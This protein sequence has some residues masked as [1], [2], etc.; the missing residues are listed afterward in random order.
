MQIEKNI[1]ADILGT[2]LELKGK[3]KDTINAR[4]DLKKN[5]D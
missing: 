5:E 2:L 4:I 3:N 1:C